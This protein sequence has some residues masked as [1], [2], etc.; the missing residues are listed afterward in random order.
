MKPLDTTSSRAGRLRWR[1]RIV[2][3]WS[4]VSGRP[5]RHADSCAECRAYFDGLDALDRALR[6][7][8]LPAL[9]R[10]GP[11]DA[12]LEQ[13]ILRAVRAAAGESG[14]RGGAARGSHGWALG[15]MAAAAALVALVAVKVQWHQPAEEAPPAQVASEDAAVIFDAMETL[16]TQLS[17]AV[18]PKAGGFVSN[19]PLQEELGSVYSDVRS[20]L[21]FL[22][23]NFL[24][25]GQPA[26]SEPPPA[27]RG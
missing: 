10:P 15:G 7:E 12:G 1:C 11:D 5:P 13:G 9:P 19:N 20:A 3:Q 23:L 16:S 21:D 17:T 24:P 8:V 22:A 14:P 27:R 4:V 2:R 25:T 26:G 18:I 6:E